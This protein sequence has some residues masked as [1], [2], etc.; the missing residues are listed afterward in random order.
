MRL[1]KCKLTGWGLR[2]RDGEIYEKTDEDRELVRP[3]FVFIEKLPS[4][5]FDNT[6]MAPGG[7][8]H[9]SPR[10]LIP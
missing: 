8:K 1:T 6:S 10:P 9:T 7:P 3:N 2:K 5:V 4:G